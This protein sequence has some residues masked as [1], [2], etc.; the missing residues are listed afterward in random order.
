LRQHD[1]KTQIGQERTLKHSIDSD[2]N[3]VMNLEFGNGGQ[4]LP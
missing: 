4:P 2:G 1:C 3:G